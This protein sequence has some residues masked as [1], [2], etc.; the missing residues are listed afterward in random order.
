VAQR[1]RIELG[2]REDLGADCSRCFGLCCVALAFA[3]S[4][5][6][7]FDKAA[8]DPCVHLDEAEACRVHADLR[9]LGFKGCTVFD[10]F[11]AGQKV[12]RQAGGTSWREDAVVRAQ[13]FQTFPVVRRL[14]ELL[15]Y[16]D[17]AI[18][19]TGDAG[20]GDARQ[21]LVERF[22]QV[23]ALSDLGPDRLAALDVDAEYDRARPLLL[24]TSE[25]ARRGIGPGDPGRLRPGSD[26]SGAALAGADLS[27]LTLRGAVL[28]GADLSGARL[29]RCDVLG[30]DLRDADLAG[31]D[32]GEAIYLTQMQ[33]SSARGDAATVLP[34]G[35]ERPSHW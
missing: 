10:C 12:S 31:A 1:T 23:R 7:P 22:E 15:W 9:P 16:L 4:A 17:Q 5:D 27:G 8:G 25:H 11:G 26:L 30:V 29:W 28:I 20:A 33:V 35:F 2:D 21:A 6:F 18:T 19:L 34:P 13:M 24:A 32:L 14:H 3:R